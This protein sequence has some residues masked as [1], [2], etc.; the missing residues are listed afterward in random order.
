MHNRSLPRGPH[1]C[2]AT[3]HA[4]PC[5]PTHHQSSAFPHASQ[6]P[7]APAQTHCRWPRRRCC[8]PASC[9]PCCPCPSRAACARCARV[10]SPYRALPAHHACFTC[11]PLLLPSSRPRPT[12]PAPP[13]PLP[14]PPPV[15]LT[16]SPCSLERGPWLEP[17]LAHMPRLATLSLS[18][19][20]TRANADRQVGGRARGRRCRSIPTI[21]P[22]LWPDM[23]TAIAQIERHP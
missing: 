3:A 16:L 12:P 5:V 6:S 13:L 2:P 19:R 11:R 8:L 1:S 17:E 9:S 22:Q 15:Q 21:R 18:D 20:P 14:C 4:F 23:R 7:F 10:R